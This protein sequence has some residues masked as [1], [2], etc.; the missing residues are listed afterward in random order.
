[1]ENYTLDAMKK[2]I[3]Q[4]KHHKIVLMSATPMKTKE[5][6]IKEMMKLILPLDTSDEKIEKILSGK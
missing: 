6:E 4:S 2:I 1:M 3:E 5:E